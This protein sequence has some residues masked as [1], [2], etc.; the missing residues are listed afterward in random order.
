MNSPEYKLWRKSVFERDNYTCIECG[1]IGGILNAD[2][3]KAFSLF[4]DLR[5]DIKNGRTLCVN[6]H[7]KTDSYGVKLNKR[8]DMHNQPFT[9]SI[10]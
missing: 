4:P 5:F 10:K 1:Q 6:C 9:L 2:H 8:K 7:K 3:I